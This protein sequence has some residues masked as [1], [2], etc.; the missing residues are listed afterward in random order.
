M[1][2]ALWIST[3]SS[4]VL[5]PPPLAGR[6]LP[7]P[8]SSLKPSTAKG[9]FANFGKIIVDGNNLHLV[10]IDDTGKSRFERTIQAQR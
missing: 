6:F 1:E 4:A 5:Y 10:I 7:I 3:S 9:G 2:T 8:T